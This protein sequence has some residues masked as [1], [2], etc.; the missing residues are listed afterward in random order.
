[1]QVPGERPA[2][3][4]QVPDRLANISG[5]LQI[6]G[7]RSAAHLAEDIAALIQRHYLDPA[8][9]PIEDELGPLADAVAALEIYME[10]LLEG[11]SQATA[12]IARAGKSL[13]ALDD[14]LSGS[15]PTAVQSLEPEDWLAAT[16]TESLWQTDGVVRNEPPP[17][18]AGPGLGANGISPEFLDI[19]LE[20][21][22][23][24]TQSVA[25]QLA[26]WQADPADK[27]ALTTL[28]RSFHTLKGSGRLVGAERVG[29]LAQSVEAVLNRVI[30][31]SLEPGAELIA[32]VAEAARLL[33]DLIAAE[34]EGRPLPVD[35]LVRRVNRLTEGSASESPTVV[36]PDTQTPPAE[37]VH[38][39]A[40]DGHLT[41]PPHAP[42]GPIEEIVLESTDDWTTR[43]QDDTREQTVPDTGPVG[44][45]SAPEPPAVTDHASLFAEDDELLD[46]FRSET[47]EHLDTLHAFIQRAADGDR[48]PDESAVRALHTLT[49]SARM[50]GVDSIAGVT[51]PLELRLR[52]HLTPA[53]TAPEDLIGLL[54]AA[55]DAIALRI[56]E[57][58]A[59]GPGAAALTALAR[60]LTVPATEVPQPAVVAGPASA[61]QTPRDWMDLTELLLPEKEPGTRVGDGEADAR[62]AD[63]AA[64]VLA[65]EGASP[66]MEAAGGTETP[67]DDAFHTRGPA[68]PADDL[69]EEYGSHPLPAAGPP[70]PEVETPSPEAEESQRA[71]ELERSL[72]GWSPDS[73]ADQSAGP[74]FLLVE[75]TATE[76]ELGTEAIDEAEPETEARLEPEPETSGTLRDAPGFEPAAEPEPALGAFP[77]I[78]LEP[79]ADFA[80]GP[81]PEQK[82]EPSHAVVSEDSADVESPPD[83]PELKTLFLEDA[84]DLLD[85]IDARIRE[86]QFAPQEL[87]VLDGINRLLHTLK[88]SA[89]LTG[90]TAIGDLSHALETRLIAV[91][92]APGAVDDTTL[93]LTQKAADT[94]SIQ[95]DA[96]EQGALLPRARALVE[97][98]SR[99]PEA[100]ATGGAAEPD[101]AVMRPAVEPGTGAGDT[102]PAPSGAATGAREGTGARSGAPQIRVGSDLLDRLVDN[103]GEISL[104]RARLAQRNGLLGFGLGE[105]DQTVA[106]LREQLRL[107]EIETEAQILHRV[108]RE[109]L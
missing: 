79:A 23:E 70:G 97:A 65:N 68:R 88:G 77:G 102:T 109:G 83:D 12:L 92:G 28:R 20:E 58:P 11:E 34:A 7:E 52:E 106:R 78:E 108:E 94:L 71:A 73:A 8:R 14:L 101:L 33:P 38:W 99:P 100:A 47:R 35:D 41:P 57:I 104:Y 103:S 82:P 72:A 10:R 74:G 107:L 44:L 105:L 4:A 54:R 21:A 55:V 89:R 9:W 69:M 13:S 51:K 17:A 66:A 96:L 25:E 59:T 46:I 81:V 24:E 27:S 48:V 85:G 98:L 6:L 5:A 31:H 90:L 43:P 76:V 36:T 42:S 16:E 40:G 45:A 86:W 53:S 39:A 95:V 63:Q 67:L 75:P 32:L 50:S 93:E 19:F 49:G 18:G 60:G 80:A 1:C 61:D 26:L 56:A 3:F 29:E 2:A 87:G 22:G 30:E 91:A 62:G 15:V 37:I 84:R 64:V